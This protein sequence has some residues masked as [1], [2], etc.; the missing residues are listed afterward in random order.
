MQ[1]NGEEGRE[2]GKKEKERERKGEIIL[3]G[4]F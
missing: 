3:K 4:D 2:G 1:M